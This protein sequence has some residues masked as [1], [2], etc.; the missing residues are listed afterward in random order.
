[1]LTAPAAI[2]QPTPEQRAATQEDHRNMMERLGIRALRPGPSGNES[3]PNHANYDEALANPYPILPNP[4]TA[5]NGKRIST[6]QQWWSLRH[7]EIVDDF[8]RKIYGRVPRDAP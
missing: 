8:E 3:A 1:M 4:L 7:P 6:P 2:A 5:R